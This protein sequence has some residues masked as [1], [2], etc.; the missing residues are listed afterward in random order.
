MSRNPG[1]PINFGPRLD[2]GSAARASAPSQH[3]RVPT[4]WELKRARGRRN[5]VVSTPTGVYTFTQNKT[6]SDTALGSGDISSPP[7]PGSSS[8]DLPT[9]PSTPS[10]YDSSTAGWSSDFHDPSTPR[11][12]SVRPV[13]LHTSQWSKWTKI[14][15]PSLIVPYR[16][17]MRRTHSLAEVDLLTEIALPICQCTPA[18][19]A[20][21][22]RGLMACSPTHPTLAIDLKLLAFARL[23]FLHMVPNTSGWCG[24]LE[25][26]LSA[27]G[28]KLLTRDTLRRRFSDGLRWYYALLDSAEESIQELLESTRL[29]MASTDFLVPRLADDRAQSPLPPSSPPLPSSPVVA[30][31]PPPSPSSKDPSSFNGSD[32]PSPPN[33]P[34]PAVHIHPTTN[35][36][37][38]PRSHSVGTR[39][40]TPSDPGQPPPTPNSSP[41][42]RPSAYLRRRCY[43]CFGS[44]D[45]VD[46][47]LGAH[48]IACVDACFTQ[49]RGKTHSSK[50]P[51]Y[52]D[53]HRSHYDSRFLTEAEVSAMEHDVARHRATRP[54]KPKRSA[55]DDAME[56][57]M[58][59]PSSVLD[60]CGDSFIAADEKREKASTQFFSD[61]GIMALLCR[62]DHCLF[63]VN[64]THKG[65]RQHYALALI[66]KFF[67]HVPPDATLGLLYDIACQLKRSM[68]NFGFLA[69]FFPRMSFAVSIF[70]AY[71]H[72]WPCQVRYHPRKCKG[73]GLSDGEGCER[74]WSAIRK[75]IPS[76][77]V[78]GYHQRLFILDLHI[79]FLE[80]NSRD[81]LGMWLNRRW[82][83]CK[84]AMKAAAA[85][86]EKSGMTSDELRE[87]WQAQVL[88]QTRPVPRQSK[89]KGNQAIQAVLTLDASIASEHA[90]I[91][92]IQASYS[93]PS[94]DIIAAHEA[95]ENARSHLKRLETARAQKFSKLGVDESAALVSLKSNK[96]LNARMNALALKQ[97]LRDR[98]RQRK[99]ELERLERS[100]RNT[101]NEMK[102]T[103]HIE[104]AVARRAPTIQKIVKKYNV[105]CKEIENM[106]K[107]NTAPPGAVA[108]DAILPGALW[109][110]DVDDSI[111][112]DIGLSDDLDTTP[113][114]WLRDENVRSGIRHMLNLERCV[115]EQARL[116]KER[117]SLQLSARE[118]WA[119]LQAALDASDDEDITYQLQNE[120][121][122]LSRMCYIWCKDSR[123][124]PC[125]LGEDW[126]PSESTMRDAGAIE[127][128]KQVDTTTDDTAF[129]NDASGEEMDYFEEEL[130]EQL[131]TMALRDEYRV[132]SFKSVQSVTEDA[133]SD[134]E[135]SISPS[136]P[137]KRRKQRR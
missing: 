32:I 27:L 119:V 51:A 79:K 85:G 60:D 88:V 98:L 46:P 78:S 129:E 1:R 123:P 56:P 94:V 83:R 77:R 37:P 136:P 86:I 80:I 14:V 89:N 18:P 26:F 135:R 16:A 36:V 111:W 112:Q 113:P 97:R 59:L 47:A 73:F 126:G 132:K 133:S 128:T 124:I 137:Q 127:Y 5:A 44:D 130:Y 50:D 58:S 110:L 8:Q 33:S 19:H 74:F 106:I 10:R 49:K 62:H 30:S 108:P 21:L 131:E 25:A 66:K 118:Q 43:L 28:Y 114:L 104:G 82:I 102:S 125:T 70:H 120:V 57:G 52:R 101:A 92:G 115:E 39:P 23:Q 103:K 29:R 105:L 61:T 96:Y 9:D 7:S 63:A 72:Q 12:S 91:R 17:L 84:A 107:H 38:S 69:E 87:Q 99:F 11:R 45:Q 64:M 109:S 4:S 6:T 90:T 35:P 122:A 76:L 2:T 34:S 15:I 75:L 65:E 22:A 41:I 54:P 3:T 67:E 95:L 116:E 31:S 93:Q 81:T 68:L 13:T 20:L 117:I 55:D 42:K 121:A 48:Y 100:Y 134:S 24:A 40:S 53:S 71:G